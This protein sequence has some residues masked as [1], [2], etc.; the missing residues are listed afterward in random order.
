MMSVN[1]SAIQYDETP[2]HVH[3]MSLNY[4]CYVYFHLKSIEVPKDLEGS[5]DK[6]C[7]NDVTQEIKETVQ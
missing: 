4:D 1:M 7:L 5:T 3:E 2:V 6:K